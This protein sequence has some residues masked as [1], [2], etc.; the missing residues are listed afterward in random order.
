MAK[1]IRI[2]ASSKN[3]M[4]TRMLT[5]KIMLQNIWGYL[6]FI[7]NVWEIE[8]HYRVRKITG[9]SAFY[10]EAFYLSLFL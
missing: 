7:N 5:K 6:I 10:S 9:K 3:I 8:G 1:A 4:I 2:C